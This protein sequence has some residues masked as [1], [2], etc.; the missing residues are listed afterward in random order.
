LPTLTPSRH[1]VGRIVLVAY[2]IS[3]LG[4]LLVG[5]FAMVPAIAAFVL[6]VLVGL[7]TATQQRS[8]RFGSRW[9]PFPLKRL[10][11]IVPPLLATVFLLSVLAPGGG[12][13]DIAQGGL[14]LPRERYTLVTRHGVQTDVEHWR[15]LLVGLLFYSLWFGGGVLAA[16]IVFQ[17]KRPHRW[18]RGFRANDGH[19]WR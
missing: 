11:L 4:V 19:D 9:V 15:F 13:P 17:A 1:T 5:R 2:L 7:L 8:A 18:D 10:L 12:V 14:L 6:T 3:Y 16:W